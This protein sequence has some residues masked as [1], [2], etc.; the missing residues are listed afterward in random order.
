MKKKPKSL[1]QM[2]CLALQ[3]NKIPRLP[4][5]DTRGSYTDRNQMQDFVRQF[6]F[7]N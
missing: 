1:S 7:F 3:Q 4:S 6:S 2:F 5:S